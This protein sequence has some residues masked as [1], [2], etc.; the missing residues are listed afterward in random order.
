[1]NDTGLTRA[2]FRLSPKRTLQEIPTAVLFISS[3]EE[4]RT[5]FDKIDGALSLIRAVA[6][7]RFAQVQR[8]IQSILVC[9]DPSTLAQYNI[10]LHMCEFNFYAVVSESNRVEEIA[11]AL[12]HEAQHGRLFRLGFG[13][14][15]PVRARIER[16]CYRAQRAFGARVPNGASLLADAS[17]GMA[18][19]VT[20]FSGAARSEQQA[21]AV[22][23]FSGPKWLMRLLASVLRRRARRTTQARD[24]NPNA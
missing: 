15:E 20:H 1:M 18:L 24:Q 23:D 21:A 6:P 10:D 22:E 9:G 3:E 13:Y 14:E 4:R 17:A 19:D 2:I 5:C 7:V 8:D 16:V 11:A 12:V